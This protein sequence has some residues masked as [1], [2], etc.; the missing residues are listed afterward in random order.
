MNQS[1]GTAVLILG[2][3]MTIGAQLAV[4]IRA[5]TLSP[6]K[7]ILCLIVP[8]YVY[9]FAKRHAVGA[10]FMGTWFTGIAL[11]IAGAVIAS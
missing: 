7:G 8:L 10:W 6:L 9:V 3:L 5:F 11:W 2:L 4:C 1:V